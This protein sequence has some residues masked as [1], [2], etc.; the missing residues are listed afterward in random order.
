MGALA[1]PSRPERTGQTRPRV[2]AHPLPVDE[3]R[4]VLEEAELVERPR[5]R[6]RVRT[7]RPA[8][9]LLLERAQGKEP[10]AEVGLGLGAEDEA[11]AAPGKERAFLRRGVG[12]VDDGRARVEKTEGVEHRERAPALVATHLLDLGVLF[13]GV[14]V[15]TAVRPEAGAGAGDE[16]GGHG[17]VDGAERVDGDRPTRLRKGGGVV[18]E[19]VNLGGEEAF[20]RPLGRA[21]VPPPLV[22]RRNEDE[23]DTDAFRRARE[24]AGGG[25]R[26]R[27]RGVAVEVVELPHAGVAPGAEGLVG[28][29]RHRFEILGGETRGRAVHERTPGPEGA[30]RGGAL[31]EPREE[32]VEGVA[33]AVDHRRQRAP[34]VPRR[35]RGLEGYNPPRPVEDESRVGHKPL[36]REEVT[37]GQTPR[38]SRPGAPVH[39]LLVINARLTPLVGGL[40]PHPGGTLAVDGGRVSALGLPSGSPA[41]RVVDARGALLLPGFVDCHTHALFAGDRAE[42]YFARLHGDDYARRHRAGGGLFATVRAVRA[43]DDET[44]LRVSAARLAALAREGVTTV[45]VKSGYGL[46]VE[47]ELRL[48]ELVPALGARAGVHAVACCLAAHAVPPESTR[49]A[50]LEA[51]LT[52]LL[53]EVARRGLA[54]LVDIYVEPFAFSVEDM[55]RLF[56]AAHALGFGLRA[57]C[58][59][60]HALGASGRAAK[61]G[62]LSCDHL[63][64]ASED[65]VRALAEAG[66]VAVLLPVSAYFL[67]QETRP[68]IEAL[69]RAGVP[70]AVATDLNPGTSFTTSLLLA[71]HLAVRRWGL[72]PEEAILGATVHAARALGLE[73]AAG[74]LAPG[75]RADFTLWDLADP[76][77]LVYS[78]GGHLRPARVFVGGEER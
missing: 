70:M 34:A 7:D 25:R 68:P 11:G 60:F 21:A 64:E 54:R 37:E 62:A 50:Y 38:S 33:V 22:E 14:D 10:V 53:P 23:A 24:G 9:P 75:A 32:T 19:G 72:R 55:E 45:E 1:G 35:T 16:V 69:R 3:T 52:T 27:P 13:R 28:D 49:E 20:L 47:E 6:V 30:G 39:D 51:I 76:R 15:K 8:S 48:L 63:E 2:E 78:L 74:T 31:P 44:L 58:E 29:G 66:T 71:L 26:K 59:Q 56:R 57:H 41:R 67:G 17:G 4:F 77:A 42:D 18:E 73:G 40:A 36:G 5:P 46:G 65:D 12:G 61:L 43:T